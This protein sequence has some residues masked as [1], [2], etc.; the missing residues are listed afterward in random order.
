MARASSATAQGL[1]PKLA[2]CFPGGSAGKECT[3]NA[4]DLGWIPGL[5]RFPGEWIS[6]PLQYSGLEN[7]VNCIVHGVAKSRIRQSN[8]HFHFL[9]TLPWPS[10]STSLKC[11]IIL[12][13]IP[14]TLIR[15]KISHLPFKTGPSKSSRFWAELEMHFFNSGA[16]TT[17]PRCWLT[18][19][20]PAPEPTSLTWLPNW[21]TQKSAIWPPDT[22]RALTLAS[23]IA[24]AHTACYLHC[25]PTSLQGP[26]NTPL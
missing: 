5:G 6:Y 15:M 17:H 26:Q 10:K 20:F 24:P 3:C 2:I 12:Y 7:S 1:N 13:N 18:F 21:A 14:Q 8:T 22:F 23:L 16:R 4:G 9:F 25:S 19:S 11:F